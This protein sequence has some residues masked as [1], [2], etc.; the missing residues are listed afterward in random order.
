MFSDFFKTMFLISEVVLLACML[1]CS[2]PVD[3]VSDAGQSGGQSG[4]AYQDIEVVDGKVRFYLYEA[5]DA[6]RHRMDVPQR[7]WA[8][9]DVKVNGV[10]YPVSTAADGRHYVDVAAS[11]SGEYNATLVSPGTSPWYG[12]SLYSDVKLPYSQFR[13]RTAEGLGTY[14]MYGAYSKEDGNKMIFRDAFAVLDITLTGQATVSSIKV[15]ANDMTLAGTANFFPS[16]GQF[17]MT[18]GVDFAV[19]NC[20]DGGSSVQLAED[21]P[22]HFHI[23]LAPGEYPDGLDITVT[24]SGHRAMSYSLPA[25]ELEAGV[26][27]TV[28]ISYSPD[29]DLVF[30]ESFDNFVWGG[31]I[32]SGTA[33]YAPDDAAVSIDSPLDREGYADAL[34]QV[35][36]N[37]PG[38][39]F[40]QS[41]TWDEVSGK[42]V[43][44]SHQVSDSYIASRNIGDYTYMFRCQEYQGILACGT[45]NT[46]RGIFQTCA[47][48]GIEG[49]SS[50]KV[51]FDFCYQAGSTDLL[52][53]QVLN[54]GYIKSVSVDGREIELTDENSGFTGVAGRYVLSKNYVTVPSSDAEA[55]TWHRVEALIDNATDGT[56][57]YWAGNDSSSG[58]HGFYLDNI[59]VRTLG[60]MAKGESN[61]R[62]LYWNI[63]NGMWSDQANNYENF[64]AWV[65][66]YDPDICVWCE[67]ASIYRDNT[68]SGQDESLRFLPDGWAS[69]AARYGHPYVAIGGWRDNYPQVITSRY[70]IETLLKITD[71]DEEGK[72]VS[73]GAAIQQVDVN[74]RKI[75]IVTLHLWPQSYAYGVSESERPASTEAHG[76]DLYREFEMKY[77]CRE[78]V[79]SPVY[80][81]QQDWLMMGDFNSRS[82][83]DNLYYGYPDDDTRLLV[84]NHIL[85]NTGLEDVIAGPYPGYFLTST[86]G[87][88]RIDLMY[89]SPSMYARLVNSWMITD[90]WTTVKKSP[91]VSNFYDP[92]DHRPV[93]ADFEMK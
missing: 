65:R 67:A 59:E 91:Y 46:G 41:N 75:N 51:S 21:S 14:P 89:A 64:V 66:K 81:A 47:M 16:E 82:R 22:V 54:G 4:D 44:S 85:D 36:Y 8:S 93:I 27:A 84:H 9:A 69:L 55:K 77:I 34:V 13:K 25:I 74:G 28:S 56:M 30:Y 39:A 92:S 86:Y 5:E 42:T 37:S 10:S 7:V 18:D 48:D 24:D 57:L 62:V 35:P 2:S 87:N 32:M 12:S 50:V 26:A 71:T 53:F 15:S 76:G 38:S 23:M 20:T 31:D 70:P 49:L 17:T 33:G 83:L 63:Q 80:S 11:A 73:H 52:L 29:N 1:G 58:V 79:N 3:A 40:I 88:A 68:S 6:A 45:G 43:A 78:T 90:R 61:L 19:L 72:P 60:L